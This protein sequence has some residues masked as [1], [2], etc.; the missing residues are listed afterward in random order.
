MTALVV[1]D[2]HITD[3]PNDAE[4]WQ[5][6]PW[7]RQQEKKY[8]VDELLILGDST[9][10]KDRHSATLVNRFTTEMDTLRQVFSEVVLLMGNHDRIDPNHPFFAFLNRLADN[11]K[12]ISKPAGI[13][14]SIGE[15][16]FLPCTD[17]WQ[18]DWAPFGDFSRLDYV[19]THQTYSGAKT[20]TGYTL[21]GIPN[22]LF[23]HVRKAAWSGD[24]H[25]PQKAGPKLAYVG[26]PYWVRYGDNFKAR[27]LLINDDGTTEDLHFPILGKHLI[28]ADSAERI[29]HYDAPAGASVKLRVGVKRSEL[30]E[31]EATKAA[32]RQHAAEKG[33]VVHGI[34]PEVIGDAESVDAQLLSAT[35]KVSTAPELFT[36]FCREKGSP[37][38]VLEKGLTFLG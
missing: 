5:L 23:K 34:E 37:P 12:F 15:C 16:L 22:D 11:V 25:V 36:T 27:V 35:A 26:A 24:I 6:F 17:N 19:F 13:G 2:L 20:E 4:R 18:E 8:G 9:D 14:L 33:W 1:A 38:A 3:H 31:W 30:P 28:A 7:L 32:L 10:A 29:M 21:D